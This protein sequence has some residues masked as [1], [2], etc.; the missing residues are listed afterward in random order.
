[1]TNTILQQKNKWL[2]W[3]F[4]SFKNKNKSK[5]K[6]AKNR[7]IDLK[8]TVFVVFRYAVVA[9]FLLNLD[10]TALIGVHD[11]FSYLLQ[12]ISMTIS[13]V[14]F[15]IFFKNYSIMNKK[16]MQTIGAF[17]F[18]FLLV[19]IFLNF[20]AGLI[21]SVSFIFSLLANFLVKELLID[22]NFLNIKHDGDKFYITNNKKYT[23]RQKIMLIFVIMFQLFFILL[24]VGT[25]VELIYE[26]NLK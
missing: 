20:V 7:T 8:S 12:A 24:S 11:P 15:L 3:G 17:L 26:M 1:M 18:L 22:F 25:G 2:P 21:L 9:I 5:V 10:T 19:F 4:E 6:F 16:M 23:I 13:L 14:I